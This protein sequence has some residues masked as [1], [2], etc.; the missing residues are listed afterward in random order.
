MKH[1]VLQLSLITMAITFLV[2]NALAKRA[3]INSL[4]ECVAKADI[5]V[6]GVVESKA[7]AGDMGV[8]KI[9]LLRGPLKGQLEGN[10]FDLADA[11]FRS[12]HRRTVEGEI[13]PE[14]G[15]AYIFFLKAGLKPQ[16]QLFNSYDGVIP[17]CVPVV[18]EIEN[19]LRKLMAAEIPAT[20]VPTTRP[21]VLADSDINVRAVAAAGDGQLVAAVGEDRAVRVWDVASGKRLW[22]LANQDE[23]LW[24]ESVRFS[25]DG[26]RLAVL[27]WPDTVRLFDMTSGKE[28]QLAQSIRCSRDEWAHLSERNGDRMAAFSPD[29][30]TI[31]VGGGIYDTATGKC[32]LELPDVQG[33]A[34]A[35]SPD[36]KLLAA[37]NHEPGSAKAMD[38]DKLVVIEVATGKLVFSSRTPT[39]VFSLRFSADGKFLAVGGRRESSPV[40][41]GVVEVWDV[42]AAKR[43]SAFSVSRLC[44]SVVFSPDGQA[45]LCGMPSELSWCDW[46]TGSVLESMK[47]V[48]TPLDSSDDGRLIVAVRP[49]EVRDRVVLNHRLVVWKVVE[50]GK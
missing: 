39:E 7:D 27:I 35:F 28:I 5:I 25:P 16:Y 23:R 47:G 21:V 22:T 32:V 26:K 4:S 2:Q 19:Q 14:L 44:L 49:N 30:R 3:E 42:A 45:L 13:I 17:I 31:A 37:G 8:L 36:G 1:T 40:L 10:A 12:D 24:P 15:K 46:R 33:W 9:K 34:L 48:R 43:V 6:M 29:G 11:F 18:R 41:A 50:T 20:T 38:G